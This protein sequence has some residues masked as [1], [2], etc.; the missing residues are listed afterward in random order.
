M[1]GR[2]LPRPASKAGAGRATMRGEGPL[3]L[4]GPAHVASEGEAARGALVL[5]RRRIAPGGRLCTGRGIFGMVRTGSSVP[6]RG[7]PEAA[8]TR[9]INGSDGRGAARRPGRGFGPGR[10]HGAG[11]DL[12]LRRGALSDDRLGLA[13]RLGGVGLARGALRVDPRT[14]VDGLVTDRATHPAGRRGHWGPIGLGVHTGRSWRRSGRSKTNG[15]RA[16]RRG[17]GR[18]PSPSGAAAVAQ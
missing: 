3:R 9:F 8:P 14:R 12:T 1:N 5:R 11:I 15:R 10:G 2:C 6:V 13:L 4:R 16:G 7:D 17:R 18:G